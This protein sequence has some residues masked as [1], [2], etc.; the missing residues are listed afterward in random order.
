MSSRQEQVHAVLE[1]MIENLAA[2]LTGVVAVRSDGLVL[3]TKVSA[4][5]KAERVHAVAASLV[6]VARKVAAELHIGGGEETIIRASSGYFLVVP[7]GANALLAI[8]LRASANLGLVR[9]ESR[10]AVGALDPLL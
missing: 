7:A 3:A 6:G 1:R 8:A 9:R 10:A 5:T 4:Q 2:D